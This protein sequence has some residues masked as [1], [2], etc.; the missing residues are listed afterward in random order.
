[1]KRIL[2]RGHGLTHYTQALNF[3]R[4]IR[5]CGLQKQQKSFC[6]A[7]TKVWSCDSKLSVNHEYDLE[8]SAK[9]CEDLDATSRAAEPATQEKLDQFRSILESLEKINSTL[10]NMK[11]AARFLLLLL[12]LPLVNFWQEEQIKGQRMLPM[13]NQSTKDI[14]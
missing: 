10:R 12:K 8:G 11:K 13:Q 4:K 1:M 7:V 3:A 9:G 6:I 14:N 2:F 5:F